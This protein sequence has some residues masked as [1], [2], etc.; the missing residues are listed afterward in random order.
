MPGAVATWMLALR[1]AEAYRGRLPLDV[2]FG[3]AIRHAREGY[4]VTR[5]QARLTAEKLAEC[6]DAPG[7]AQ[8]FLID[9][10]P[11]AEGATLKQAAL[12]AT[13]D[14]L[15]NAGLGDFYRGDVGRE[16]AADLERIGSP[17]TRADLERYE[18][19]VA[20]PLSVGLEAGTLYNTPPPT[21]GL[22]SL[23]ILALF[24]R[25][26]VARGRELRSRARDHRGDQARV[27][28]ARPRGH[29]PGADRAA[30]GALSR[31]GFPRRRG[32]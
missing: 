32:G 20:E 18:A 26:R 21:Q 16:I 12:A 23:I 13:L 22:A 10:K 24:E 9:G 2:L 29:R 14:Q 17:V 3:P 7:F 28:G 25:L 5:S 6:R 1:A 11:P 30:A 19:K 4:T 31:Q 27:S 8:T 15:A